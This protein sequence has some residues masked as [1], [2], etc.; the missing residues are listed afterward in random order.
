MQIG[1]AVPLKQPR[2]DGLPTNEEGNQLYE[3][4]DEIRRIFTPSN[5]S[6]F[7]GI[8]TTAGMREFFLYTSNPS[9]ASDKAKLLADTIKHHQIQFV[10]N[11]DPEWNVYK[12]FAVN[13]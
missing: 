8:I 2:E 4:E 7:A 6:L 3:I 13:K 11:D 12:S 10:I 5:E 1:I 9:A